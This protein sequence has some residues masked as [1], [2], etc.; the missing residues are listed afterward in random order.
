MACALVG[1]GANVAIL[2]RD[3]A[4]A[5][6]LIHRFEPTASAGRAIVVYGDV[7]QPESLHTATETVL[8]EF[9]CIDGLDQ[10]GGRQQAAGHDF[11]GKFVL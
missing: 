7:L 10:C 6:T 8:K 5:E 9:G 3:T 4:L 11:R 2:D 1:C